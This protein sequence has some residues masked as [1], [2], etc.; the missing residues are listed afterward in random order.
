MKKTVSLLLIAALLCL[1]LAGCGN[2]SASTGEPASLSFQS[3]PR[4]S[5]SMYAL[6][7]APDTHCHP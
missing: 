6:L 5:D 2:S 1:A 7:R 4:F 3:K